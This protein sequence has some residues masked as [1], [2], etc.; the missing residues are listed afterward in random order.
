MIWF[1]LNSS[2]SLEKKP[3]Q[4]TVRPPPPSET[5]F[6]FPPF[7]DGLF[8]SAVRPSQVLNSSPLPIHPTHHPYRLP[9]FT[10]YPTLLPFNSC[11]HRITFYTMT[12]SQPSRLLPP[13]LSL[14]LF[15]SAT[16]FVRSHQA[17]SYPYPISHDNACRMG[18]KRNCPGPCPRKDLREDMTPNNPSVTVQ[19]GSHLAVN[20]MANNH[21]GGFSRW[22]LVHVRDMYNHNRHRQNAF[23]FSCTDANLSS[24]SVRFR[25]R[26]CRF[27]RGNKY[28]RHVVQIP[29]IYPDGVYVLGW[30][31]YGGGKRYGAFGD[32]YDCMY[33]RV[34]GGPKES[35]YRPQFSPGHTATG[36]GGMCRAT[37]NK[38]GICWR[39]P[40]PGGGQMTSLQK[41]YEFVGRRPAPVPASRFGSPY[42]PKAR[43]RS[44]PYVKSLTIRSADHSP[45]VFVST[46]QMSNP[47]MHLTKRMRTTVTCE[48][49]GDVRYVTFYVNGIKRRTDHD[50]PYTVAGDWVD[51]RR[52]RVIYAPW[53]FPID[54]SVVTLSCRAV[55]R[56]GTEHW[57]NMEVSTD[58]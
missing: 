19:R 36:A 31:W 50:A 35:S 56:D 34:Q 16:H 24:C 8:H 58:Y 54:R 15:M 41:P 17:I 1:V 14:L 21:L 20:I 9:I 55:G 18:S 46:L 27:D 25:K 28:F 42:Q 43:H 49:D 48:V 30:V 40:C 22:T 39:E 38:I 12:F 5:G 4:A 26:D 37:V 44:S 6:C 10:L 57:Q 7:R 53:K 52:G 51:K 47:Y 3:D 32:Y 13:F 29:K 45:K 23:L 2:L 11:A 33:I